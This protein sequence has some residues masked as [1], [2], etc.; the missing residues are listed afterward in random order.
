MSIGIASMPLLTI[1]AATPRAS[2]DTAT[3]QGYTASASLQVGEGY[4]SATTVEGRGALGLRAT[5]KGMFADATRE[6]N[7]GY[8]AYGRA[9]AKTYGRGKPIYNSGYHAITGYGE[10]RTMYTN[11]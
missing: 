2:Y 7:S 6:V 4:G 5:Y 3:I 8:L 9:E 11:L 10:S 1:E